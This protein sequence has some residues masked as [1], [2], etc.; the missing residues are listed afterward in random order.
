[1]N[2]V[3]H[4]ITIPGNPVPL[5]RPRLGKGNVY[6]SQKKL[7]ND[8]ALMIKCSLTSSYSPT[9]LPVTVSMAFFMP[10]GRAVSKVKKQNMLNKP[11]YIRP[12]IDNLI[13]FYLDICNGVLYRDDA[14]V[15]TIN[16]SK[17]YSNS[18]RTE[19]TIAKHS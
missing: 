17:L 13:K 4:V 9:V 16:A 14:Q 19:I 15:Y 11:H 8:I 2:E 3:L 7:K 6:D 5:K 18:P 10:I 12:D 1:M